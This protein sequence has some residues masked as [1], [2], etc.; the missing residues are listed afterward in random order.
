MIEVSNPQIAIVDD[1]PVVRLFTGFLLKRFGFEIAFEAENGHQAISLMTRAETLPDLI[2]MDIEMPVMDGFKTASILKSRWPDV[3]II[4]L[5]DKNDP[6]AISQ[7]LE[8]GADR[9]LSKQK[10][11]SLTLLKNI[12]GLLDKKD[13]NITKG[14]P[15]SEN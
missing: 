7:I 4:A 12:T 2:L 11:I 3:K 5:S 14:Y 1:S 10:D 6:L 8:A 13:E 15:G 9:F